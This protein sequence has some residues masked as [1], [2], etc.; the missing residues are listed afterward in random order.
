MRSLKYMKLLLT[1]DQL[2]SHM[3][4]K[5]ITF[6]IISESDAKVFLQENNY[7]MKLA[8]YRE[9]YSKYSTGKKLDNISIL[10]LHILKSYQ[11]LICI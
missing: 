4:S 5:G 9:N 2:I 1:T 3:K 10:I 8:S 6:N 11:R 7:Y